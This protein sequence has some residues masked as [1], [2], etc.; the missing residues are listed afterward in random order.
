VPEVAARVVASLRAR[1]DR[2]RAETAALPR[3]RVLLLEWLSPPFIGS[4]WAPEI[5]RVAG[6]EPVLGRDA[7]PSVPE[8]WERI[9]EAAPEVVL[10]APCG[11]RVEQALREMEALLRH[12]AFASLPAVQRGRV[13][14]IDGSAYFNRPGPRLVDSAEIA[15]VALH[16]DRFRDRFSFGSGD[17]V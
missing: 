15:A 14:V 4:H 3:P 16:P 5:L 12:P 11:F 1:L 10:V 9:V 8:R 7:V 2:L 6:G 17:V 13:V